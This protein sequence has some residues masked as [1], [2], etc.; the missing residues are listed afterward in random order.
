MINDLVQVIKH[1]KCLLFADDLKLYTRVGDESDCK[2]LQ[3]DVEEIERW[4]C[5]N[6]LEFNPDKCQVMT[7]GRS[8]KPIHYAYKIAGGQILKRTT[9]VK[10][11]G[12][13]FDSHLTFNSHITSLA[14]D[15]YR[16]LG[17]ILRNSRNFYDPKVLKI[18]F[19]SL[20]RSKIEFGACVWAPHEANYRLLLE[21]IQKVFVRYLFKK[22]YG[23]YPF[24]YP[25]KYLL[26]MVGMNAL[27]T[28]RH[29]IELVTA[30]KILRGLVDAPELHDQLCAL[31][32]PTKYVWQRTCKRCTL[33]A[34][35]SCRT[36][37]R[38]QAPR[39]RMMSGLNALLEYLP[40]CDLFYDTVPK[41]TKYVQEFCE[42]QFA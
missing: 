38:A 24:L 15:T 39:C 2:N 9:L 11:L 6:V 12:V 33:L 17:F 13:I 29:K 34:L 16:R 37:A 42:R 26:G 20:V 41:L 14:A 10:D 22:S 32:A 3:E 23:Y 40:Q 8:R 36:V 28:R 18:L 5:E 7:F 31:R 19:N 21:R 4:A 1:A 25:T 30:I 35:P 27:E